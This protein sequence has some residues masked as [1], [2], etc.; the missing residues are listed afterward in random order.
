M[1]DAPVQRNLSQLQEPHVHQ[2]YAPKT[3]KRP[4]TMDEWTNLATRIAGHIDALYRDARIMRSKRAEAA[5]PRNGAITRAEAERNFTATLK[6]ASDHAKELARDLLATGMA[7]EHI[8]NHMELTA[9]DHNRRPELPIALLYSKLMGIEFEEE[10]TILEKDEQ[11][12]DRSYVKKER[13]K[14][15]WAM[16]VKPSD[17]DDLVLTLRPLSEQMPAVVSKFRS[18]GRS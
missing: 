8:Q 14:V 9:T 3:Q 10:R 18:G 17:V 12:K 7:R 15:C 11:G 4:G 1:P 13:K 16:E 6:R 2:S 5:D